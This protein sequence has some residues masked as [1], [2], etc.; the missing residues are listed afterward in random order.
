MLWR[1]SRT[2]SREAD[3]LWAQVV[4]AVSKGTNCLGDKALFTP[5][6]LYT[7]LQGPPPQNGR[8]LR[9]GTMGT[10][11]YLAVEMAA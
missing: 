8:D 10:M 1:R 2:P 11:L 3:D 9:V 6:Q 7:R 5:H 4:A